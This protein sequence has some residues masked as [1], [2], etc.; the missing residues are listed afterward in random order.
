MNYTF[1]IVIF[2]CLVSLCLYLPYFWFRLNFEHFYKLSCR[3]INTKKTA[4]FFSFGIAAAIRR[5]LQYNQRSLLEQLSLGKT[6]PV[7]TYLQKHGKIFEAL[8]LHAFDKPETSIKQLKKLAQQ[9]PKNQNIAAFIAYLEDKIQNNSSPLWD[10]LQEKKLN[11]YFRA[12]FLQHKGDE[13]LQFGDTEA[14]TRNYLQ[15]VKLFQRSQAFFEEASLYVKLG[16]VYR[17]CFIDDTADMMF[18]TAEEI[19]KYLKDKQGIALV[20]ACRGQ[21]AAGQEHFDVAEGFFRQALEYYLNEK[22]I[23]KAAEIYNQLGLLYIMAGQSVKASSLLKKA[24]ELCHQS[25]YLPGLAFNQELYAHKHWQQKQ[26]HSVLRYAKQA[27][28]L[29]KKL[30]NTSGMLESLYLQAEALEKSGALDNAEK[31]LR[32]II[33]TG[34]KDAGCFYLANAYTLLGSIFVQKKDLRR[35]KGLF[36]QSLDLEQRGYRKNA[37][38]TDYA[39]IGLIEMRCGRQDQ[40]LKNMETALEYASGEKSLTKWL[41]QQIAE[42]KRY[43]EH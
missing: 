21:L 16:T 17:V 33:E 14:A 39:N 12:V 31:I 35:A 20:T 2:F 4:F 22:K 19:F 40:A 27:A 9:Y 1:Y 38:A 10:N 18:R 23:I 13:A 5:L 26:I 15:S 34:K 30:N 32:E 7:E 24:N 8:M 36:Q 41:E 3:Q 6:K 25:Q 28:N 43:T 37:I 11:P 29:Y 42:L